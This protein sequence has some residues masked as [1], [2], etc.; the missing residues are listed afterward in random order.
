MCSELVSSTSGITGTGLKKCAPI[1]DPGRLVASASFEIAMV[2]VFEARIVASSMTM[3]S[4]HAKRERFADS[5]ST[6]ASMTS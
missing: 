4:R 6:M 3:A 1:T 2:E 5:S